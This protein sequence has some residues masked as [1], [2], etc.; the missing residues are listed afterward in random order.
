M[1]IAEKIV[2]AFLIAALFM[3]VLGLI[4]TDKTVTFIAMGLL[5]AVSSAFAVMQVINYLGVM[6]NGKAVKELIIM[7]AAIAVF[8]AVV[9]L[10]ILTFAGKL[11]TFA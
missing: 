11:F 7:I 5:I 9:S 1:K 4:L 6:S 2:T 8:L 3:A 10:S